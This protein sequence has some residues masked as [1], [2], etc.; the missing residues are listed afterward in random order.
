MVD[1]HTWNVTR[2]TVRCWIVWGWAGSHLHPHLH[3]PTRFLSMFPEYFST[4]V[5][6]YWSEENVVIR[7]TVVAVDKK[8]LRGTVGTDGHCY[9]L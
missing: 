9:I 2:N 3:H 4:V 8:Q 5:G 1:S 7:G 6:S